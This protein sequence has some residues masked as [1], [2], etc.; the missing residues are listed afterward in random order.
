MVCCVM[1]MGGEPRAGLQGSEQGWVWGFVSLFKFL[2]LSSC[3]LIWGIIIIIL[4][5]FSRAVSSQSFSG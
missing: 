5:Y 4:L 1:A 3:F 2:S